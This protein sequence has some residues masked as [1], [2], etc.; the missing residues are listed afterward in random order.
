MQ[1]CKLT[2]GATFDLQSGGYRTCAIAIANQ[3]V[4]LMIGGKSNGS[5]DSPDVPTHGKVDR[6]EF[7][8]NDK[9]HTFRHASVSSTYP[10]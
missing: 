8:N 1:F 6:C 4:F 9:F 10:N 5:S 3:N 2:G 7:L